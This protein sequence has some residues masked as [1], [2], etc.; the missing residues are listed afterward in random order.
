MCEGTTGQ[1]CLPWVPQ[2]TSSLHAR[3]LTKIR[4]DPATGCWIWIGGYS[5]TRN[6]RRPTLR[7]GGQA[8]APTTV[9]R[10]VCWLYLGPPPTP[11]HEAGHTCPQGENDRCVA[12]DHLQWMTRTENEAWKRLWREEP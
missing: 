1:L 2:A 11:L 5:R 4:R 8:T 7:A 12:P 10:L 9:A 6:G 3:I